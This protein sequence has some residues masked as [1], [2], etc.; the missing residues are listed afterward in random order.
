MR[1]TLLKLLLIT[2]ALPEL[3]F[4][5]LQGVGV[6]ASFRVTLFYFFVLLSVIAFPLLFKNKRSSR[7]VLNDHYLV[8]VIIML[9]LMTL[10][11][12]AIG[13]GRVS[14]ALH[15][16]FYLYSYLLINSLMKD[17]GEAVIAEILG[18]VIYFYFYTILFFYIINMLSYADLFSFAYSFKEGSARVDSFAT[19]P[20][21]AAIFIIL[22][23]FRIKIFDKITSF[24]YQDVI[25][26]L[27]ILM[28]ES[29]YGYILLG[30]VLIVVF[31]SRIFF[32]MGLVGILL[33]LYQMG[34]YDLSR[35]T[36]IFHNFSD[37]EQ[38]GT[39]SIRVIPLIDLFNIIISEFR[40]SSFI[41]HG[42]GASAI[43]FHDHY[44]GVLTN[45]S[46]FGAGLPGLLYDFGLIG[47]LTYYV[48][49]YKQAIRFPIVLI[50]IFILVFFNAGPNTQLLLW[51]LILLTGRT[52]LHIVRSI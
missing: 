31:K 46:S 14:A 48:Y 16:V 39:A 4:V 18:F 37:V 45:N 23:Y 33:T 25:V 10:S 1:E 21:Y 32:S 24:N 42:P 12:F 43:Y 27:S 17:V 11:F 8:V 13:G 2:L 49:I 6:Q 34:F 38:W 15:M 36:N 9:S 51:S 47:V 22:A 30:I 40:L 28:L 50:V 20:S 26:I 52:N 3:W 41:G 7:I 29:T 5:D 35:L 19:E 44:Y